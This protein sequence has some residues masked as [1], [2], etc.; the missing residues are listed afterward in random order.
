[1]PTFIPPFFPEKGHPDFYVED[2]LIHGVD[3]ILVHAKITA[4]WTEETK[5][6]RSSIWR[7]S[8]KSLVSA[9]WRKF[10]N[11]GESPNFEPVSLADPTLFESVPETNKKTP[12]S[13]LQKVDGSLLI[14]SSLNN[15]LI[16]RTRGKINL[17]SHSN[18]GELPLLQQKYPKAFDNTL[19][20]SEKYSLLF[21]W[22]TPSN[23]II[24][25]E[26]PEPSLWLI[27]AVDH[28]DYS[29]V[30]QQQLDELSKQWGTLRP[31]RFSFSSKEEMIH[32][33]QS[34]EDMEGVVLFTQNDQVLKKAKA[35]RYLKL[36]KT[37]SNL[38][39]EDAVLTLFLDSLNLGNSSKKSLEEHIS[40]TFDWEIWK[41]VEPLIEKFLKKK[42]EV[43]ATIHRWGAAA[44]A[45]KQL[46]T[47]KEQAQFITSN[48]PEDKASIFTL[49][50]GKPL[51]EDKIRQLYLTPTQPL[52]PELNSLKPHQPPSKQLEGEMEPY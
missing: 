52:N 21:E 51:G 47:R 11:L 35:L 20:N 38:N 44:Q 5:F 29:Y 49:L 24:L 8:D 32:H 45:A 40:Q 42:K 4:T 46:P 43:E 50:D 31:K 36:H 26:T 48:F 30:P 3:C 2:H 37:K 18:G 23:I 9:G 39:N 17:Q 27:G 7:K 14:V 16:C 13:F 1:M 19:L 34:L 25:N 22:T 41:G 6:F 33:V 10:T 12:A 28:T 15:G